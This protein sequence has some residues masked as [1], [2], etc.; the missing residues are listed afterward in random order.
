HAAAALCAGAGRRLCAASGGGAVGGGRGPLAA[1]AGHGETD[2]AVTQARAG[3]PGGAD[4]R[5]GGGAVGRGAR[6]LGLRSSRAGKRVVSCRSA[7]VPA[8]T[9][10]RNILVPSSKGEQTVQ[11]DQTVKAFLDHGEGQTLLGVAWLGR[12]P[13]S[14]DDRVD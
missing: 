5:R 3:R 7:V 14:M 4:E 11:H 10:Y 9:L 2:G 6:G 1:A 8:Y 13:I 12:S